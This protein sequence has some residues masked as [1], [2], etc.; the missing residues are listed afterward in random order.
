[1]H[2]EFISYM[3]GSVECEGYVA[4][5][6]GLGRPTP[7]V[8]VCHAWAGQDD[9]ARTQ[10][11]MLGRLGYIGFALDVYGKGR[12]G[13]STDENKKLMTPFV[14]DRA[15]LRGRLLAAVNTAHRLPMAHANE[16]AAI[17]FCF[18]G[19]C[20]L[21]IARAGAPGVRG[22]VSFHGLF[23]APPPAEVGPAQKMS[24]RVLCLHGY[25]DPMVPPEAVTALASDLTEAGA[26]W[27][28]D[29][30]GHTVHAFTNPLAN[31][32]SFGTVYK[33]KVSDR[34][35]AKMRLFLAELF[36]ARMTAAAR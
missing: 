6:S 20:A 15:L 31:D 7:V 8:L 35:F 3:D 29:M 22:V 33:Q 5:A 36:E 23:N 34:A 13:G 19:L 14:E 9:F 28:I 25:A 10:A 24:A 26:D 21:D 16:I 17:G 2:T 12:R 27:E 32:P 18:G 4:M 1:M 11:E 30:Y